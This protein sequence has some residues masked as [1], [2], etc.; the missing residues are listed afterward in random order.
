LLV[1]ACTLLAACGGGGGGGSSLSTDPGATSR[2]AFIPQSVQ[3]VQAQNFEENIQV[4]ATISPVPTGA[5]LFAIVAADKPV[6]QTGNLFFVINPDDSATVT[7]TTERSLV[8]GT[9]DGQLTVHICRDAQCRD[10]VNL[11][12]NVLPYSIK[13]LPA[14]QVQVTGVLASNVLG[15]AHD[16][17]VDAGATVVLTSNIPVTWSRGSSILSA[18]LQEI[19]STPTR[20]EGQ[21]LGSG[22]DF[23]GILASAVEKPLGNPVQAIFNIRRP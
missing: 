15:N 2:M 22:G 7:L 11:T 1:T 16:Y 17:L 21:I 9:Y 12:G 10:E 3:A 20:W 4:Q 8:P 6:I 18:G 13:V 14:V 19:S 23:I 5:Q